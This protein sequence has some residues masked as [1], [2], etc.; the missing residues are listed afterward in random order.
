MGLSLDLGRAL[1]TMRRCKQTM[2]MPV[3]FAFLVPHA[4]MNGFAKLA[5]LESSVACTVSHHP[6]REFRP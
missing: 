5:L 3:N 2:A 4:I 6:R 1:E